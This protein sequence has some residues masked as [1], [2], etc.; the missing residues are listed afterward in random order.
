MPPIT[1]T[2]GRS[3]ARQR[4]APLDGGVRLVRVSHFALTWL[5]SRKRRSATA[6]VLTGVAHDEHPRRRRRRGDALQAVRPADALGG[7]PADLPR[8]IRRRRGDRVVVARLDAQQARA[9]RRA[10]A[11]REDRPQRDRHLAEDVAGASLAD[12]AVHAVDRL[13]RL[14]A[15]FQQ[16]EQRP[17]VAL[18]GGELTGHQVEVGRRLRQSLAVAA[19]RPANTLM[20]PI[21]SAVT[22][23]DTSRSIDRPTSGAAAGG[24]KSATSLPQGPSRQAFRVAGR[25]ALSAARPACALASADLERVLARNGT[26]AGAPAPGRGRRLDAARCGAAALLLFEA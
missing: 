9:L 6:A 24:R 1:R 5:R 12:D 26:L 10:K 16:S 20:R 21:S 22:M 25:A 4:R 2:A 19:S 23:A 8:H 3:C 14:D 15:T 17:L 18:V 7:Q 13:D 11:H